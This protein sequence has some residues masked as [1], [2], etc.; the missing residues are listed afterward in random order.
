MAPMKKLA[1]AAVA[2]LAIAGCGALPGSSPGALPS[3]GLPTVPPDLTLP[4]ELSIPPE[5]GSVP[6]EVF[7]QAAEEAA[8]AANVAV[9]QVSLMRASAVTWSDSS[10][11]CPE[12][13]MMY[14]QVLTPGYWLVLSA[15]GQEFDFRASQSLALR[16]CPPGQGEP[17]V[18]DQ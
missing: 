3:D 7:A 5:L 17:P 8:A 1:L 16:L 11:G 13:D 9:D 15:G 4:P 6:P 12:P 18:E 14:T 10:L 2:A